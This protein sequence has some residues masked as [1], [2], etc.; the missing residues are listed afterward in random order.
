MERTTYPYTLPVWVL[1][2]MIFLLDI[3]YQLNLSMLFSWPEFGLKGP[4]WWFQ[5][6]L[7]SVWYKLMHVTG[8]PAL[9]YYFNCPSPSPLPSSPPPPP[10]FLWWD[11]FIYIL[12]PPTTPTW[13]QVTLNVL[14][15]I[16]PVDSAMVHPRVTK[17]VPTLLMF[18]SVGEWKRPLEPKQSLVFGVLIEAVI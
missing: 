12:A 4:T 5:E 2:I 9:Y 8:L 14:L 13:P 6:A 17:E 18:E 11:A 3:K 16:C 15:D 10:R 1:H 7:S